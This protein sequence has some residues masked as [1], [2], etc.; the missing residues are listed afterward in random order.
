MISAYQM[1][2]IPVIRLSSLDLVLKKLIIFLTIK[3]TDL[4]QSDTVLKRLS[5]VEADFWENCYSLKSFHAPIYKYEYVAA[6]H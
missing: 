1:L 3:S 4:V 6:K 5:K 2:P